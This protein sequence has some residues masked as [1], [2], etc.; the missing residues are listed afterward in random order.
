MICQKCANPIPLDP[1][2]L[3]IAVT[4]GHWVIVRVQALP[5]GTPLPQTWPEYPALLAQEAQLTLA[6]LA[7]DVA[8]AAAQG[9]AYCAL[10]LQAITQRRTPQTLTTTRERP[11]GWNR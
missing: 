4:A 8:H 9:R 10:W 6:C 11:H 2:C 7:G 3:A 1:A 5:H